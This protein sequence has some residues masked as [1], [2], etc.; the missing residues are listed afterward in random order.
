MKNLNTDWAFAQYERVRSILPAASFPDRWSK[1]NKIEEIADQVDVFLLDAFGVLNVGR[2]VIPGAPEWVSS[3]QKRG[4]KV[5]VVANGSS[6][7]PE[8][9]LL[10]FKNMGF[11]FAMEDVIASRN[12][13]G[14]TL[15]GRKQ[16]LWGVMLASNGGIEQ[17]PVDSIRLGEN[18]DDFDRVEGFI[19]F[20]TGEWSEKQ[21]E[22]LLASLM[23]KSRPVLVGNPDIVAPRENGFSL[24][25]GWF[26]HEIYE[27]CGISP[28]FFG[29]PFPNIYEHALERVGAEIDRQRIVMVGD[30]LHTDVWGGAAIGAKTVLMA[31]YGL[32]AGLDVVPY[33]EKSGIVPNWIATAKC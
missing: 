22:L 15:K 23:E 7:S 32:F 5:L 25:P 13:L 30:T 6:V 3:L 1:I 24:E 31:D 28:E 12:V 20:G 14:R 16:K 8:A 4:K 17:I 26:A 2:T 9:S 19:L 33:I 27:R 21:Q 10:R 11:D 18:R 29:K